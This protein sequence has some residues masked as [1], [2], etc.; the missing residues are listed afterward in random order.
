MEIK[1]SKEIAT[2]VIALTNVGCKHLGGQSKIDFT[3]SINNQKWVRASQILEE[4]N[5]IR[6]VIRDCSFEDDFGEQCLKYCDLNNFFKV[7][8]SKLNKPEVNRCLPLDDKQ[9]GGNGI[10]PTIEIVGILPKII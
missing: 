4:L 10:P 6:D 7:F 2:R 8:E 3:K 1:T 5:H 9:E